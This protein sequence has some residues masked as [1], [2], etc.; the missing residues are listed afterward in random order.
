[1]LKYVCIKCIGGTMAADSA[2]N[3]RISGQ[4]AEALGRFSEG[5]LSQSLDAKKMLLLAISDLDRRYLPLVGE[6]AKALE[7]QGRAARR[8][9]NDI[10]EPFEKACFEIKRHLNTASIVTRL[11][12]NRR[13]KLIFEIAKKLC[14]EFQP[15]GPPDACQKLL[16]TKT[17]TLDQGQQL[18]RQTIKDT[19]LQ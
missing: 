16:D 11:D 17:A 10:I 19:A 12:E 6:V 4:V 1:M 18:L 14:Q 15:N 8:R 3:F 2:I 13:A 5:G 9:Q 7:S